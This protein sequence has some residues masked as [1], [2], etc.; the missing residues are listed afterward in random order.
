MP[1]VDPNTVHNPATGTVAPAAWGDTIRDD[2]E[3]LIDPP[4]CSVKA[5]SAQSLTNGVTTALNAAT[6]NF[7]NNAMHSTVTNNSRI[8]IQTAG[9]YLAIALVRYAANGNNS[10][11]LSF[12]T[13]GTVNHD[14]TNGLAANNGDTF[15]SGSK[16][17]VFA[18]SDYIEVRATQYSGGNLDVALEDFTVMYLTR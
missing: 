3:F 1:Y 13:N 18:V 7:D 11:T 10:R 8:T 4:C 17:F 5:S 16:S 15:W 12:F 9:R 14:L 2:L 6:E